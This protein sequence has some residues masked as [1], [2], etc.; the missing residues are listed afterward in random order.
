MAQKQRAAQP[1]IQN[2]PKPPFPKQHLDKPGLE[3]DLRP[4]PKYEAPLY[5]AAGKLTGKA[6][7]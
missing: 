7:L 5:K 3:K 1:Q 2:E 4:R 6:A